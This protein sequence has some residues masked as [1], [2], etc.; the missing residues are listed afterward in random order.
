V[1]VVGFAGTA[2][3]RSR[4][5][6][7]SPWKPRADDRI[8]G[9]RVALV[10]GIVGIACGL[11]VL[12]HPRW[13]LD[14]FWDGQAAPS[15]YAALTYADTFL[16]SQALWLL[17]LLLLNI[18]MLVGVIVQGRWSTL[19]RRIQTG[20]G[21]ITCAVM[22]WTIAA[23]PVFVAPVSDRTAKFFLVLM[24]VFTLVDLG[25]KRYRR[26]RPKPNKSI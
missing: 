10:T 22:A 3:A 23:G 25:I 11:Y 21:L 2:W 14:F 12:V 8:H 7:T 26:V 15:A 16:Q 24:V 1:L 19:T 17:A 20:L 6:Q 13:L 18:P 4:W 5:P 9:G